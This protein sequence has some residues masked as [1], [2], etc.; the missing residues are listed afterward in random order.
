[1]SKLCFYQLKHS[2]NN[3]CCTAVTLSW[4]DLI[5]QS[6]N[7]RFIDKM[8]QCILKHNKTQKRRL[9]VSQY[10]LRYNIMI[11]KLQLTTSEVLSVAHSGS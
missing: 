11:T 2:R 1:V 3:H 6:I 8:T 10:M 9:K 4:H 7:N 5:N